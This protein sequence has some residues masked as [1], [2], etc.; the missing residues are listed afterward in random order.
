MGG[1][2]VFF[3][4]QWKKGKEGVEAVRFCNANDVLEG[5]QVR[6][7]SAI[8]EAMESC[9]WK[10]G[11]LVEGY[12]FHTSVELCVKKLSADWKWIGGH[13]HILGEGATPHLDGFRFNILSERLL[14]FG[15]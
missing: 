6:S 4:F 11:T 8:M 15:D 12:L 7:W 10:R 3:G 14:W 1:R 2:S 9:W 5:R 13:L